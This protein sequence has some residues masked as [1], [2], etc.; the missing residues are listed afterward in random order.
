MKKLFVLLFVT[1]SLSAEYIE[2][3]WSLLGSSGEIDISRNF[4]DTN[5]SH[6]I[7]YKD[8]SWKTFKNDLNSSNDEISVIESGQ[9]YWIYN[10]GN[11]FELNITST[12]NEIFPTIENGWSLISSGN[13]RIDLEKSFKDLDI[14]WTFNS[15][16]QDWEIYSP[17]EKYK[18]RI[19]RNNFNEAVEV[20]SNRG[21]W[22]LNSGSAINI[23]P[24]ELNI[25][26]EITQKLVMAG[27]RNCPN[28]GKSI[29]TKEYKDGVFYSTDEKF[30]CGLTT[31]I[32]QTKEVD[33]CEI[34]ENVVRFADDE[35][36]Y[37][38]ETKTCLCENCSLINSTY[39]EINELDINT[40]SCEFGGTE[41]NFI[42]IVTQNNWAYIRCYAEAE[43][44][45]NINF[46]AISFGTDSS[47]SLSFGEDVQVGDSGD[48]FVVLDVPNVPSAVLA[49]KTEDSVED[50]I[51][52][53]ETTIEQETGAELSQVTLQH[54][55]SCEE[56]VT[57]EI[58]IKNPNLIDSSTLLKGIVKAIVGQDV[59]VASE[60]TTTSE[61][62]TIR[63][64]ITKVDGE[65]FASVSVVEES[66]YQSLVSKV[67]KLTSCSNVYPND[68]ELFSNEDVK[69]VENKEDIEKAIFLWVVD[70]SGSMGDDQDAVQKAVIDFG[71]SIEKS[72]V[73]FKAGVIG[74][75]DNIETTSYS[76]N[77]Y[78]GVANYSLL[79][80]GIAEDNLTKLEDMV[81]LGINGSGT[82]TGIYNAEISLS[83]GGLAKELLEVEADSPVYVIII[84]DEP[85]QYE[86]RSEYVSFDVENNIFV[87]NGYKVYALIEPEQNDYSQYDD[88]ATN[89]GGLFAN[90]R[91]SD[92]DG[93]LDFSGI[94]TTIANDISGSAVG[95]QLSQKGVVVPSIEVYVNNSKIDED[96]WSYI[97]SSN[98][99]VIYSE[100]ATND[101]VAVSYSY[102]AEAI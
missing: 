10:S 88:L 82:E 28:G 101:E 12:G 24:V 48:D 49:L 14:V 46:E 100:L 30:I 40:S 61:Y 81:V 69:V 26:T 31:E 77:P 23:N 13:T 1:L 78:S 83:N 18:T 29:K 66:L 92:R 53:L 74:T 90:I 51:S 11:P 98:S 76:Y 22:I 21:F 54:S 99:I 86:D 7:V 84:S 47:V 6:L 36:A 55:S 16:I 64:T 25:S 97:E 65:V 4:S 43:L 71:N 19:Q 41:I 91:N 33:D 96:D 62:F 35:V 79:T 87:Q 102:V 27:D 44:N 3:G 67:Q 38:Y 73:S 20:G 32:N 60:T 59:N 45:G 37:K 57:T 63:L 39:L 9:G 2:S 42:D 70:D 15:E 68:Y 94:M 58:N 5:V 80:Y 50:I 85:S 89:T 72:G 52:G 56:S 75:G 34:A 93:N 8:N 95:I 17:I